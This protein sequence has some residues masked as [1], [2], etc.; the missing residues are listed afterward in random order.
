MSDQDLLASQGQ[1]EGAPASEENSAATPEQNAPETGKE[2]PAE[3]AAKPDGEPEKPEEKKDPWYLRRIHQQTAKIADI[4][5]QAEQLAREKADLEARIAGNGDPE[6][7]D[8]QKHLTPAELDRLIE[9]RAQ[10][11][12]TVQSFN[13]ACDKT[14]ET[15]KSE[16]S[17]FDTAIQNLRMMDAMRPEV[18]QTVLDA[19]GADAHKAL[20]ALGKNPEEA[21]RVLSLS[22][23]RMAVE[24]AKI[25]AQ[26]PERPKPP[27][28][29]APD[30]I[31]PVSGSAK[32]EGDPDKMSMS[33]W[34]AWRDKSLRAKR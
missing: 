26:E 18:I 34:M 12:A 11:R 29:S 19:T 7:P 16:F 4:S 3:E 31:K 22:P 5:R 8:Q 21:E 17:D 33:E 10:E 27:L 30:P 23:I 6:N 20:Y 24:L 1:P 9:H 14:Y 28:S 2:Q 25:A 32:S 15:G 13:Q